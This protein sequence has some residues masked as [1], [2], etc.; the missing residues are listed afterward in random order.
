[1]VD[2]QGK[3]IFT[4]EDIE[5]LGNKNA[6]PLDRICDVA[7]RLSGMGRAEKEKLAKNSAP[8]GGDLSSSLPAT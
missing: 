2:D 7:R 5:A 4:D 3:R 1:V 8:A 6:A